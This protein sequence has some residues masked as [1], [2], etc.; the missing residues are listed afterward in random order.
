MITKT[1]YLKAKQIVLDY[2][3]QELEKYSWFCK[4]FN[5]LV[6]GFYAERKLMYNRAPVEFKDWC[7]HNAHLYPD[8][9][10]VN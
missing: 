2:E 1:K 6:R 9:T 8:V 10:P 5:A 7:E 3:K 4:S